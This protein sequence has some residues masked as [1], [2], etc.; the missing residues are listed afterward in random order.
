[1]QFKPFTIRDPNGR[2]RK[3]EVHVIAGEPYV[4][5]FTEERETVTADGMHTI[6]LCPFKQEEELHDAHELIAAD[7]TEMPPHTLPKPAPTRRAK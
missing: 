3:V 7:I 2:V 5:L 4:A 6:T 1:M